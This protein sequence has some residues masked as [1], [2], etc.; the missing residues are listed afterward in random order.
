MSTFSM[1]NE[2]VRAFFAL[3]ALLLC[4]FNIANSVLAFTKRKYLFGV[5]SVLAFG[6]A[7]TLWQVIFDYALKNKFGSYSNLTQLMVDINWLYWLLILFLLT[8]LTAILFIYN[9]HYERNNLTANSIKLYLDKV[10]CGVCCYKDNGRL[11]FSNICINQLST[12]ITGSPILNGNHF[13]ESLT[14]NLV[15]VEDEKW[16]FSCRDIILNNEV[17]HEIKATNVTNEYNKTKDLEK[18]KLELSRIKK[19]LEDYNLS[20]NEV[21]KHQEILQ[22]KINI[23]DEMNKLML[24]TVM[25]EDTKELDKIFSLW[26]QNTLLLSKEVV[27]IQVEESIKRLTELAKSLKM[28]LVWDENSLSILDDE[29]KGVFFQTAQEAIA[30][31]SKHASAT[32]IN[33][34]I[35]ELNKCINCKFINK[36]NVPLE[37]VKFTGGL[38]NLEKLVKKYGA[39]LKAEVNNNDFV[40]TLSFSCDI[41]PHL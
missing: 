10:D 1:L 16:M 7:Y 15:T 12:K 8:S 30:N 31:A 36:I 32:N 13:K 39:S 40:L 19:E 20:I 29:Q 18:D 17:I 26:E 28:T 27:D 41:L 6:L 11:L 35:E 9:I 37:N 2:I 21:V 34:S 24:S 25:N 14:E 33:I 4:L 3:W 22:A 38:S 23:H 5:L